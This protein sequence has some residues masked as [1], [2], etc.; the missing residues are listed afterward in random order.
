MVIAIVVAAGEGKRMKEDI[1][2]QFLLLGGRPILWYSLSAF[3][4]NPVI[5]ETILVI[6][7]LWKKK[8]QEIAKEF[9]KIKYIVPGGKFRQES[10]WAGLKMIKNAEIVLVHDGVRP[11]ISQKLIEAVIKGA[12][13]YG[14][15]VPALPVKETVK[16]VEG[17][18]VKKTLPRDYIWLIQTPQG[19]KFDILKTAYLRFRKEIFTDDASLVEKLGINVHVILGEQTNIKITIPQDLKWAEILLNFL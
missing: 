16:W 9:S 19:F 5:N 4:K 2:K 17:D 15:V 1:P 6:N 8:G 18:I 13:K 11:F 12:Y 3:E 10:V 7:P 14:A